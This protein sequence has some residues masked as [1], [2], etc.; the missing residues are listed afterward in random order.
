MTTVR[1]VLFGVPFPSPCFLAPLLFP[2]AR[3]TYH[4]KP[5]GHRQVLPWRLARTPLIRHSTRYI[6]AHGTQNLG[7]GTATSQRMRAGLGNAVTDTMVKAG[8]LAGRHRTVPCQ[9]SQQPPPTPASAARHG[10]KLC[11]A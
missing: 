9:R 3:T 10:L 6:C 8:S 2:L 1:G 11:L 7:L 4:Y 5:P